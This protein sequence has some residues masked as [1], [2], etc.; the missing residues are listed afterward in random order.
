MHRPTSEHWNATK[1]LLQYLCGTLTHELFLHKANTL[2]L[3]A[4]L[5]ADW[6]NNKDEYISTSAY[7]VYLSRHPIS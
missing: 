5:D 1:R 6:A 3:H 7:I 2:S 4:F